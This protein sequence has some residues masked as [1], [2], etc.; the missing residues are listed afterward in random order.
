MY[1]LTQVLNILV[2]KQEELHQEVMDTHV[3]VTSLINTLNN[4]KTRKLKAMRAKVV[5]N[6]PGK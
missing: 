2:I 4:M 5:D 6:S 1:T 3:A